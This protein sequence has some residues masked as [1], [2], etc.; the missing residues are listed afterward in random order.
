MIAEPVL[1]MAS[2]PYGSAFE[3]IAIADRRGWSLAAVVREPDQ[4]RADRVLIVAKDR[5]E[6]VRGQFAATHF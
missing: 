2:A 3:A 1:N 6:K 5:A 4:I